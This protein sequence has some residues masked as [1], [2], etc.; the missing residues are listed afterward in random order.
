M[1]KH[2]TSRTVQR[3]FREA[4]AEYELSGEIE[5]MRQA[6]LWLLLDSQRM[7]YVLAA[8]AAVHINVALELGM[9]EAVKGIAERN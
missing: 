5:P 9:A 6:L 8:F 2:T 1:A 4:M 3:K 7:D